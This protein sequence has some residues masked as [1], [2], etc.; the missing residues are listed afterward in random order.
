M[1]RAAESGDIAGMTL[2]ALTLAAAGLTWLMIITASN[3]R[4]GG[5]LAQAFS[6]RDGLPEPSA[7]AGRA[8]RAAKNML[9]NMILYLAVAFAVAGRDPA[10]V[11]LGAEIF[12]AARAAHW[13]VYLA[14]ITKL[15]TLLYFASLAGLVIMATSLL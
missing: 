5:N 8:D 3:L 11:Q 13:L 9:E 4:T 14:G 7:L 6:N 2:T 1:A 10:R 12:L 15:R